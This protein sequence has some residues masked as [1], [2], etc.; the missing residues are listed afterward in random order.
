MNVTKEILSTK[1]NNNNKSKRK[2]LSAMMNS[3]RK[4]KQAK[5]RKKNVATLTS[6]MVTLLTSCPKLL[7]TSSWMEIIYECQPFINCAFIM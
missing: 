5:K 3:L 4:I 7:S 6:V 1:K 2:N